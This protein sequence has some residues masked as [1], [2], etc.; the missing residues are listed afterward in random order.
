MS[1]HGDKMIDFEN[2]YF[3][4]LIDKFLEKKEI[5]PIWED[6]VYEEYNKSLQEPDYDHG[7]EA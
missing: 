3:D 4:M 5:R 7:G 1:H 2:D 6:F